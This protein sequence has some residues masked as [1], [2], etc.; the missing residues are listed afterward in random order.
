MG[1]AQGS[2]LWCLLLAAVVLVCCS[3]SSDQVQREKKNLDI[4]TAEIKP[5]LSNSKTLMSRKWSN[6]IDPAPFPL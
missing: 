3:L 4:L 1:P 5:A 2:C 6:D